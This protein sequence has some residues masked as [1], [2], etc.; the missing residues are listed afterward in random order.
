MEFL[1]THGQNIAELLVTQIENDAECK[2]LISER[3]KYQL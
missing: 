2:E 1:G 3:A